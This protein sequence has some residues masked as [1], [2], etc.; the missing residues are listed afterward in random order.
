MVRIQEGRNVEP[1]AAIIDSQS[2]K[3]ADQAGSKGYDGG[4]NVKGRKRHIMVDVLGLLIVTFVSPANF[5]DRKGAD[6]LFDRVKE[7]LPNL[8][9]IWAD[10][11]Y[12]GPLQSSV[13][14]AYS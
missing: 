7:S 10:G 8:I 13:L 12:S 3:S 1:T 11:G 4:K 5:G 6:T 14:K 2:V 9:K